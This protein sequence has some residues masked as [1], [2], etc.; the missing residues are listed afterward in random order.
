MASDKRSQQFGSEK[1]LAYQLDET[2]RA[3]NTGLLNELLRKQLSPDLPA[4]Q[5]QKE[6]TGTED[7]DLISCAV[8]AVDEL[9][10]VQHFARG[11]VH[12]K[13]SALFQQQ[14][15]IYQ[16]TAI[17]ADL[18]KRQFIAHCGLVMS[19]DNCITTQL[20]DIRVRAFVRGVHLAIQQKLEQQKSIH[21]VYPACGPFAPLLMPLIGYYKNRNTFSTE[22]LQV[23]LID[24]QPGAVACLEALVEEM[25]IGSYIKQIHCMDATQ[26]QPEQG[27]VD[28]VVLE[29]MQH[30]LSREGH[31]SIARRFARLLSPQGCFIP[32]QVTVSAVLNKAHSEFVEQWRGA[33]SLSERE[34]NP[35]IKQQRIPLG[36]ILTITAQSLLEL[37][38][39]RL[40]ENTCLLECGT[41]QI[42][43]MSWEYEQ[44]LLLCSRVNTWGEEWVGEYDSGITHPLPDQSVCINFI[45]KQ[46]KDGDL[47]VKSGD[48]IKFYYRLNG[49][50]GFLPTWSEGNEQNG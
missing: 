46:E 17:D 45:P 26:Y 40:D 24:V 11:V 41:V 6:E 43:N 38:E 8:S 10:N 4:A 48:G 3:I 19:P 33:E 36:D 5:T 49:L 20:D 25:A 28:I 35:Q 12:Q 34:M 27:Y 21:L 39:V 16:Q 30:G 32:R 9:L 18:R 37:S 22:Q 15:K 14:K 2:D 44:T 47:L 23:T 42:P 7:I 1:P 50:P 29:A 13:L 31:L